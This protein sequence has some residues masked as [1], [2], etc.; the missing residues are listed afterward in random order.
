MMILYFDT[1]SFFN[2]HYIP[3][4]AGVIHRNKKERKL[5]PDLQNNKH[6]LTNNINLK[7]LMIGNGLT[8]PLIQYKYYPKMACENNYGPVLYSSTCNSMEAAFSACEHLIQSCY[9]SQN[10]SFCLPAA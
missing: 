2:S 10:I 6:T 7:S 3:A 5:T 4:I 8:D 1:N 9:D